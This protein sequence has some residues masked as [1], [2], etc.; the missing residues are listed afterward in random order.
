MK[1]KRLQE[2]N[3]EKRKIELLEEYKKYECKLFDIIR[4]EKKKEQYLKNL[5]ESVQ[6]ILNEYFRL[7]NK[8]VTLSNIP[9][10][11]GLLSIALEGSIKI[12][13][14]SKQFDDFIAIEPKNR[15]LGKLMKKIS[16]DVYDG[17]KECLDYLVFI[18][19]HFVHFPLYYKSF[20]DDE[21]VFFTVIIYFLIKS[22][23]YDYIH[24]ELQKRLEEKTGG[25]DE[26][27]LGS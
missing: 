27:T 17:V 20:Y 21:D 25:K 15:T 10:L 22:G 23:V 16:K 12:Y 6:E 5:T 9:L 2:T 26:K 4:D 14:I 8:T 18:R 1:N 11:Y 24:P 13:F 7:L 3:L 19:N